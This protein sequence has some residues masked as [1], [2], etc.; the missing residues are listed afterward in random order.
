MIL[1][2][3]SMTAFQEILYNISILVLLLPCFNNSIALSRGVFIDS[4]NQGFES[5]IGLGG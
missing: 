3:A 1:V 4:I 2:F 5:P